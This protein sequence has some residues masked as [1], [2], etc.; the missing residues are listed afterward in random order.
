L[1]ADGRVYT[2]GNGFQGALGIGEKQFQ[3]D[4]EDPK[5]FEWSHDSVQYSEDWQEVTIPGSSVETSATPKKVVQ[6]AAGFQSTLLVCKN[7]S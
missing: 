4:N 5:S 7:A 3:L 1:T 6:V 2:A